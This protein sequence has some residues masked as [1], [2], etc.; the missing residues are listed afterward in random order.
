MKHF[1][2]PT[3]PMRGQFERQGGLRRKAFQLVVRS[4][5]GHASP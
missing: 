3:N 4:R 1:I 2:G 5:R